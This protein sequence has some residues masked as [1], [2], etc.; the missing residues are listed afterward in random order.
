VPTASIAKPAVITITKLRP[1]R[2]RQQ[3]PKANKIICWLPRVVT[4]WL[5]GVMVEARPAACRKQ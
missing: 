1:T 2:R 5:N 3:E 4:D